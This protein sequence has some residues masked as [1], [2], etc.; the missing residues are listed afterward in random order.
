MAW[1]YEIRE[2][3]STVLNKDGCFADQ[4]AAN[5]A[6]RA[7]AKKMRSSSQPGKPAIVPILVGQNV[8]KATR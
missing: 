4:D 3:N 1:F 7:D 2:T 5:I 8:E 6:A